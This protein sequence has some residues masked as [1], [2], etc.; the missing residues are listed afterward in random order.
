MGQYH[1]PPYVVA[2]NKSTLF[3]FSA[4]IEGLDV[5]DEVGLFDTGG[6][7]DASGAAGEVLVGAG[8]WTG[9]QLEV[10]AIGSVDLS[11]FGGP[12]LPGYVAGNTMTLKV[13]DDCEQIVWHHHILPLSLIFALH[14]PDP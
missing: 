2:N 1:L 6:I 4:S 3:I 9:S 12:I 11:D 5:G 13:W 14:R 7:I 8:L 10:S